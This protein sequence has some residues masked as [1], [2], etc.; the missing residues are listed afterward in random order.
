MSQ[1]NICLQSGQI[2]LKEILPKSATAFFYPV[3]LNGLL[4]LFRMPTYKA[5]A[6]IKV[7]AS[8][9]INSAHQIECNVNGRPAAYYLTFAN[10]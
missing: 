1:V 2:F 9:L 3:F 5:V 4:P 8:F 6:S 7:V 10:V